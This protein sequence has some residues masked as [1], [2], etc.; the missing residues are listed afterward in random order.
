[1]A[2]QFCSLECKGLFNFLTLLISSIVEVVFNNTVFKLKYANFSS[3]TDLNHISIMA[4]LHHSFWTITSDSLNINVTL[5]S[6]FWML[7]RMNLDRYSLAVKIYIKYWTRWEDDSFE[8]T[9]CLTSELGVT[10]ARSILT[11][12]FANI[13][14]FIVNLKSYCLSQNTNSRLRS[15]Y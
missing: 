10:A 4:S 6:C 5:L 8:M 3:K 12:I 11:T 1:M 14:F 2:Q 13:I 15:E 9:Y 7:C